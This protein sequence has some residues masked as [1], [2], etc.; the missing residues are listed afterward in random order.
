[1]EETVRHFTEAA[2]YSFADVSLAS[3]YKIGYAQLDFANAVMQ[4]P[5][6][7]NLSPTERVQYEALL[8]EQVSPYRQA[9]EKSFRLTLEQGK[10]AGVENE[11]TARARGALGEFGGEAPPILP[12]S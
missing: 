5:R 4:A 2:G 7:R 3:Y 12:G 10:T 11:W 9:A 1:M 6:P 8:R